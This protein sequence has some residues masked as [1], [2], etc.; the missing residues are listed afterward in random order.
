VPPRLFSLAAAVLASVL[1]ASVATPA[2]AASPV[3]RASPCVGEFGP[4]LKRVSCGVLSVD[5]ARGTSS[6]RRVAIPVVVIKASAPRAGQPPVFYLHGGPGGDAVEYAGAML[7]SPIGRDMIAVDQDWVFFDQRG[8]GLAAPL[9]E[10]GQIPMN[11][12]GP[13]SPAAAE[14]LKACAARHVAAGVDLSRYNEREVALDIQDLRKALGYGRIDLVGGSYGTSIALAALRHA[15]QGIRAVVL[16]SP[17]P[18]EAA[19]AEGGPVLVSGAIRVILAKCAA[20]PACARRY[21]TLEAD[22]DALARR[23]LAGPQKGKARSYAADDLGGFLMDAAYS[24][25][26]ARRLPH[27]LAAMAKGDFS[28]LEAHRADR[29]PYFE[30][31][32]LTHLCKEEMPFEDRAKVAE[33]GG[34]PVAQLLVPSMSRYFE[35]CA[36]WPVGLPHPSDGVAMSSDVPTLFLAAEIDPG[37]PPELARA[38]VARFSRGQL[39]IAPNATHGV[40]W[41]SPCARRMVRAFLR[42]PTAKV[43][44][45]CLEGE[46]PRF[47]FDYGEG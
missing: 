19:W 27:D 37:C 26:G 44:G 34:D 9:L 45:G 32:H 13:L 28:A 18:P 46:T 11:D 5:E 41:G 7:R 23:F 33:V 14:G 22:V 17:W 6:R 3:Y 25:E 31:Q 1:V 10:C 39:F 30:G 16:D 20:D 15:P 21:P 40:T 35:V 47:E 8:S 24:G 4:D 29:S 38:A 42:D 2:A 43:D 12:A 36:A